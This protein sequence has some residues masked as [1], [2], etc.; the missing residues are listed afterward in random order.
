MKKLSILSALLVLAFI[1]VVTFFSSINI[2]QTGQVGVVRLFGNVT[3][4]LTPGGLNVR[5]SWFYTVDIYDVTVREVDIEFRAYSIDA[6]GVNGQVSIQY[7]INGGSA[8]V[9]AEQFGNMQNLEHRLHAMLL[10]ETQNVF[11]LKSAMELVE[12]RAYLSQEIW[13]RITTL[14]N[15]FHIT[16][17]N[18]AIEG[19]TFSHSFELAVEQ[20]AVADQLL[21]QSELDAARDMVYAQRALDVARLEAEAVL[22]AVQADA[23]AL[24]IMQEAWGDL[25]SE[26]REIMLRQL[27]IEAWDGVLPQVISGGE[28]SLILDSIGSTTPM[29]TQQRTTPAAALTEAE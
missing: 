4:I 6:Q 2:I 14:Q 11:A 3:E 29:P 16:I 12:Q 18:V 22:V 17:T 27:A 15:N 28:F 25:G 23:E 20:R 8:M 21:R 10:Q 5:L 1:A 24:A 9:V 13:N 19:M 7:Q 26:V